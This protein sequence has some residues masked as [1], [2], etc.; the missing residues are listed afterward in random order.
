MTEIICTV[1][2]AAATIICGYMAISGKKRAEREDERAEHKAKEGMLQL[3]M[4]DANSKLTI[5]VAMALKHGHCNGEVE[6]G[7]QAVQEASDNYVQFLEGIAIDQIK[8]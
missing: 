1:I 4:I 6:V 5:G 8:K 2:T 7:L 3:Q